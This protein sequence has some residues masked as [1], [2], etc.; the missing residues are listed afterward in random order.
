MSSITIIEPSR[1][2][3]C[4]TC[5][6]A[7]PQPN[8]PGLQCAAHPPQLTFIPVPSNVG[9]ELRSFAGWPAVAPDQFCGEWK[10]KIEIATQLPATK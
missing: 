10:Q 6:W 8:G 4:E 2:D 9:V 3:R 7:A 5:K 1:K